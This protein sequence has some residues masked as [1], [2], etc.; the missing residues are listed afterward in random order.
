VPEEEITG[1][2]NQ[3]IQVRNTFMHFRA[4]IRV[5]DHIMISHGLLIALGKESAVP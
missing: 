3:I 1:R 2:I 4:E 5:Y